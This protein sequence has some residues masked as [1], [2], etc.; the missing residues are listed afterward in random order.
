MEA[1]RKEKGITD[2][3]LFDVCVDWLKEEVLLRDQCQALNGN[4]KRFLSCN[5]MRIF[6]EQGDAKNQVL[7]EGVARFMLHFDKLE[8][9][10]QHQYIMEWLRYVPFV[11]PRPK[12]DHCRFIVPSLSDEDEDLIS[13]N[14]N[15]NED[16]EQGGISPSTPLVCKSFM[17]RIL[18]G[19]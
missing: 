1:A 18:G 9:S 14:E 15:G 6:S 19:K 11:T 2:E 8:R 7:M 3:E 4:N 12:H 17:M 5:C 10:Q 13:E 16:E